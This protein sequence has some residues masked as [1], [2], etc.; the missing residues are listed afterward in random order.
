MGLEAE[1]AAPPAH[2]LVVDDDDDLRFLLARI[3]K[4][5]GYTELQ[6]ACSAR[7][8]FELLDLAKA[9][10]PGRDF[11]L[12]LMD[13]TMPEI[14]GMEATRRLKANARFQDLPII[15][16]TAR[17]EPE[18]LTQAFEAGAM[19]YVTKPLN[20]PEL[21]ARVRSALRL[22]QEMDR[23]KARE[24]ELMAVT[25]QLE[26]ANERLQFLSTSDAL[27]GVANRRCFEEYI[28][29]EWKRAARDAVPLSL[30]M[31]DIDNFKAFNDLYGHQ[32]GDECLRRVAGALAGAVNRPADRLARYGGEEFAIILPNT[33]APGAAALAERARANVEALQM[34]H[35]GARAGKTV[36]ISLGVATFA[37]TNEATP[38][39][40]VAAADQALYE[41]KRQGR[42]RVVAAER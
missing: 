18:I 26:A 16:V 39:A 42:N 36:T 10:A 2:I 30:I 35:A 25:A 21:I 17:T 9:D 28:D 14:D 41:A 23:R 4:N 31:I 11:D 7:E 8:A 27:T 15:I 32:A 33:E 22:K 13:F 20:R 1:Q 24:R 5:A 37:P 19:D 34:P 29:N 3:L 38:A 40:L 6:V 12:I